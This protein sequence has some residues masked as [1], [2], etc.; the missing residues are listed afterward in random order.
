MKRWL[1]VLDIILEKGKG[2]ILG[3]LRNITLI[4]GDIQINMRIQLSSGGEEKIEKDSRFS[5]SNYGSRKNYA[6]ESA[7]L[8]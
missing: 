4:E 5:K 3:K 1:K 6:I 7:I 8:Q 2:P